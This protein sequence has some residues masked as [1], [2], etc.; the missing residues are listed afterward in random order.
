MD[1]FAS[2][3][4]LNSKKS[5]S[6]STA[7]TKSNQQED[8]NRKMRDVVVVLYQDRYYDIH[9]R[10]FREGI[11]EA[12]VAHL[13][14]RCKSV[15]GVTLAT[16]KLKVSGANVKDETATLPSTG[17]HS[18]SLVLLTGERFNVIYKHTHTHLRKKNGFLTQ[19][20]LIKK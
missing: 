15:T 6:T 4:G 17:I 14:E 2:F 10:D 19:D 12:T 1:S 16:M 9:F 20:F 8:Y 5:N 13:K 11:N 7:S 3:F 18:G